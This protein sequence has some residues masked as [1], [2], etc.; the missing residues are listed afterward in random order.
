MKYLIIY[1]RI[2]IRLH[3]VAEKYVSGVPVPTLVPLGHVAHVGEHL[4]AVHAEVRVYRLVHYVKQTYPG[5]LFA[6]KT[7]PCSIK[8]KV[9][10]AVSLRPIMD[11]I[12]NTNS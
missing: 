5:T 10:F 6:V 11:L 3:V 4:V 8:N 12:L 9:T 1:F 2:S 7:E